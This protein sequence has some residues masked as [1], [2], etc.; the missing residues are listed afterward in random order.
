MKTFKHY[1]AESTKSY[2]L[3]IK[4]AVEPTDA[5]ISAIE[6]TLKRYELR[7]MNG[8]DEIHDTD[9]FFD[10]DQK[11]IHCIRAEVGTPVSSYNLLQNLR[12]ALNLN[13]KLLAV[14][15]SNEPFE[16]EAEDVAFYKDA[17]VSAAK[18]G[19]RARARLSTS[20]EYDPA[21]QPEVTGLYGNEYNKKLLDY[22]ADIAAR[23]PP[24][25]TDAPA[26]LF[27]W[28]QMKAVAAQEPAQDTADFNARYDTPKAVTK[29][30]GERPVDPEN[31]GPYGNLDDRATRNV[32]L[33][34]TKTGKDADASQRRALV[35]GDK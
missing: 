29:P 11:V 21:E 31:L 19:M 27:S 35:K 17:D 6:D 18:A 8:P 28:L 13:E 9:D 30:R 34:K 26:P 15:L 23:R 33:L 4:L 3:A 22:L 32:K 25:E 14:R 20:R 24:K 5:Q 7:D 16:L 10:Q 2:Y 1:L 12:A